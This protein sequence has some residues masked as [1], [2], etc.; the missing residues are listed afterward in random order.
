[1]NLPIVVWAPDFD[2]NSGGGIV[3][4][5]LGYRLQSLGETI[6]LTKL[7]R[8][9]RPPVNTLGLAQRLVAYVKL[10]NNRRLAKRHGRTSL[11]NAGSV[12]CHASMPL[13]TKPNLYQTPFIAIYPEIVHGNPLNAPYVIRWL[14]HRPNFH[15]A[16]VT[17][18]KNELIFF[19]QKV[20]AEDVAGVSE[21]NLLQ[22][23]WLRDDIYQNHGDTSRNGICR[24]I[25]KGQ[26][27]FVE[28][29]EQ[30]DSVPLLDGK[31]HDEIAE[32]FNRCEFF[33][34]HDPYTLYLYYA[35]LCGC[36]PVVVPQPGLD[37]QSWRDG[38]ELK[39][40]VAYGVD[41]IPWAVA[42]RS[43]LLSDMA[44]ARKLEDDMVQRFLVKVKDWTGA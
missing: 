43:G 11:R 8:P 4:H 30:A 14:L 34:C 40:G 21:D 23:R 35:A 13:P 42:T 10:A 39:Q 12:I 15:R 31:S 27:T 22:V 2:E 44:R 7:D 36:T 20:F 19:Y 25:R 3:L 41:E 6:Y 32:A 29:I 18:S 28:G 33:Y 37:A 17:F 16:D 9:D 38:F 5:T 26:A 1:M 24:M